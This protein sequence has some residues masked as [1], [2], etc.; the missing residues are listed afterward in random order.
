M[1]MYLLIKG[2]LFLLSMVTIFAGYLPVF[3]QAPII[4]YG[5]FKL[6]TR[7]SAIIPIAPVNRGGAVPATIYSNTISF[8]GNDMPGSLDAE[9]IKAGFNRPA[10]IAVDQF[11]NL[12]VA[13][14]INNKIRK[15]SAEGK[16]TTLAGSGKAGVTN[17][18]KGTEASF[19]RP[20]GMA[21]DRTG[22]VFVADVFNHIIRK[23]TPSGAV[24][25]F[26]GNGHPGY[27][28]N[29]KGL[30]SSFHFPVDLT[31][32]A[33]GNLFVADEGNNTIRKITPSG[34]VS[35]FAGKGAAGSIDN[36]NGVLAT[37]NQ[38][39]G[40]AIDNHS[41]IYV[42]DQLNHKIRKIN[43]AG[44]VSTLAGIGQPGSADNTMGMLASFNNPRGI[45]VDAAG[46]VY[47]GDVGNQKIRKIT[48]AGAVSTLSGTGVS[49]SQ[50]NQN[51]LLASF[52]FPNGLAI[53]SL[54]NLF[55]ADCLNNK[56]RKIETKGYS[57]KPE[58]L[59]NG[60]H[61]NY[62]TGV[63]SGTP[64]EEVVNNVYTITGYNI[65]GSSTANLSMDVS[66]QPGNALSFDGFDDRVIIPD[67]DILKSPVVSIELWV[68]Y[69]K[70]TSKFG[71]FIVKRN[72]LPWYDDSYSI[73]VDSNQ[74]FVAGVCSG[75]GI[76][77]GQ[78]FAVQQEKII[79]D[80][81]YYLA[82]VFTQDS[83][84]LYVN[85]IWQQS[86]YT[87]FP[88]SYG[89]N[90]L[91]LGF[92]EKMN[93]ELDE[94]RVF[95]TDR[96][97]QIPADM[98]NTLSPA[99]EGLAAYYNCNTGRPGGQNSGLIEL[100][101][102]TT[103]GNNGV[104]SNF[105]LFGGNR[106]N[107]VKS[108]AMMIPEAQHPIDIADT[109]F[110]AVWSKPFFGEVS[111]YLLDVSTRSD[112]SSYVPGYKALAVTNTSQQVTGLH[113]DTTYYFRI[114]VEKNADG[115]MGGYSHIMSVTTKK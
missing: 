28:D 38:P 108:Y 63:F 72:D 43:S 21:V 37:F 44:M 64:S 66:V 30:E 101:D 11:G 86:T 12:F 73:G 20:G 13:D 61:F 76:A 32:D 46:N 96:S 107:W 111:H 2:R 19:N 92:D 8:A 82:A 106:S 98:Y 33:A 16:V 53:D 36:R 40:I 68:N 95:N 50:D 80:T 49:G 31:I 115:V 89:S 88:L 10:K 94:V 18:S 1:M 91:F 48:A 104:L 97:T 56:I 58:L 84:K 70:Q 29:A 74:R 3:S 85:G 22:N 65:Y 6:F 47:V 102:L 78:K 39:N 24:S 5:G 25:T 9:G 110:T 99:T 59:P 69:K 114:A 79:P 100:A 67:A 34:S 14:E 112:F 55:V 71:R 105:R 17:S 54:G 103:N 4:S 52:Y 77:S 51:G 15:I 7:D 60:L 109:G 113:P 27:L 42:A 35:T 81:W 83:V 90:G 26:A 45:A 93:F 62:T 23:I 87:G 41:N 75:S 57:I